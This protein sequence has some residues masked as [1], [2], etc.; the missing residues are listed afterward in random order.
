MAKSAKQGKLPGTERKDA[1]K[2]IEKAATVYQEAKMERV[3]KSRAEMETRDK[4]H[5]LMKQ[6][7]LTVYIC[8]E[9][10]LKVEIIAKDEKIKVSKIEQEEDEAA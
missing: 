3:E 1:I 8:D 6:H 10:E 2:A 4:L 9:E 7:G 5:A